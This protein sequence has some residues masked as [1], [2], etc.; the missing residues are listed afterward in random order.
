MAQQATSHASGP[1]AS[2]A[3]P[4]AAGPSAALPSAAGARL[5]RGVKLVGGVVVKEDNSPLCGGMFYVAER[6]PAPKRGGEADGRSRKARRLGSASA[7]G[8]AA[9]LT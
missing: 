2:G 8:P 4:S 7:V 3:G 1:S 5:A 9:Q 6:G